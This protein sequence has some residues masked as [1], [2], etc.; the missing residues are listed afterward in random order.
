MKNYFV[1][2]I[3]ALFYVIL[4]GPIAAQEFSSC[5]SIRAAA[6]SDINEANAQLF[7]IVD[8]GCLLDETLSQELKRGE[9]AKSS[10]AMQYLGGQ[11]NAL[12]ASRHAIL[13]LE[14]AGLRRAEPALAWGA[15]FGVMRRVSEGSDSREL[16]YM[17]AASEIL[18][19]VLEL[20]NSKLDVGPYTH[21]EMIIS[22]FAQ[23]GYSFQDFDR[24]SDAICFVKSDV[25]GT[26]ENILESQRFLT[27]LEAEVGD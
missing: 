2:I 23:T 1:Q 13:F 24:A 25:G 22:F 4:S 21:K 14:G 7:F 17:I 5:E 3:P 19:R 20:S 6:I 8:A 18:V 15:A 11:N 12:V 10:R 27:C 26:I 9:V 16:M